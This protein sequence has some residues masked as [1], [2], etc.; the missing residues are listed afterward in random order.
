[1]HRTKTV[2]NPLPSRQGR[3]HMRDLLQDLAQAIIFALFMGILANVIVILL[4]QGFSGIQTH[5]LLLL[6]MAS[7]IVTGVIAYV[8]YYHYVFRPHSRI[9]RDIWIHMIYDRNAVAIV[10]DPFDGYYPQQMSSQAFQRF[11]E[12]FPEL[13][14]GIKEGVPPRPTGRHI[15]TELAEYVTILG[16]SGE[17]LGF[18]EEGLESDRAVE[19]PRELEKNIFISFFRSVE[20]KDPVDISMRHIRW[21]LPRDIEIRYR[22]PSSV[23][24][25]VSDPNTF[26]LALEG[27]DIIV[28]L[29]ARMAGMS[30]ISSLT[31]GPAPVFEGVHIRRYYQGDLIS[32]LGGLWRTS[33]LIEISAQLKFG[34]RLGLR[35][36]WAYLDWAARWIGRLAESGALGGLDWDSFRQRKKNEILVDMYQTVKETEVALR[37]YL[38]AVRERDGD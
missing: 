15:L 2:D 38:R 37:E 19:L 31:S 25:R 20:P 1:M 3:E 16:L 10:D 33:F 8:R 13:A 17:L 24:G 14:E 28:S 18:G 35:R 26:S 23:E 34:Y 27:K 21:D 6:P 7:L 22:S 36:S 29:R 11:K 9:D 5:F 12:E 32:R 4:V 30:R